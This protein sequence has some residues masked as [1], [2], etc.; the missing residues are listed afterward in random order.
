M[1]AGRAVAGRLGPDGVPMAGWRAFAPVV[2][3][4]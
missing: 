1:T 4:R 2:L 3:S